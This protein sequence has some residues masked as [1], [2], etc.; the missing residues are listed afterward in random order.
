M[1]ENLN[2]LNKIFPPKIQH[3]ENSEPPL[4]THVSQKNLVTLDQS[5]TSD[6]PQYYLPDRKIQRDSFP[7]SNQIGITERVSTTSVVRQVQITRMPSVEIIT[8]YPP[9]TYTSVTHQTRES[10]R[11]TRPT[12]IVHEFSPV[13]TTT[14]LTP[15]SDQFSVGRISVEP[16]QYPANSHF[17]E[18]DLPNRVQSPISKAMAQ[19]SSTKIFTSV[20]HQDHQNSAQTSSAARIDFDQKNLDLTLVE[21]SNNKNLN[22]PGSVTRN[23]SARIIGISEE[24]NQTN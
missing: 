16:A 23:I 17:T 15:K 19:R 3:R 21:T 5:K 12:V 9:I 7:G 22:E 24:S 13:V 10:S 18:Q 1:M 11:S 2:V 6:V 20:Q 8:T 4:T 14:N